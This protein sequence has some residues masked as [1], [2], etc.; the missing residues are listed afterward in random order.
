MDVDKLHSSEYTDGNTA[1]LT[2]LIHSEELSFI[3]EAHNALSAAVAARAGFKALW[4]SGLTI[5]SQ[6]GYRDA[7][8]ASW[9]EVV[10]VVG[11]MADS[12]GVPILVDGDTGFGN[13]NNARL[14]ARKLA[15]HGAAGV[16]LEDKTYP[17]MNSFVGDRHPLADIDEFCG[18][19]KAVKDAVGSDF[20]V[21]ARLEALIAGHGEAEALKRA[22]AYADAGADAVLIHSRKPH[23]GEILS[24]ARAWQRR[25]P[26]VI[27]PTKYYRTP[28][29]EY[30]AASISAVI[31]ANH[32]MRASVKAMHDVCRRI[33]ADES[34]A[35]IEA[36]VASLETL[37][38][39]MNYAELAAAESL[40]LP[41]SRETSP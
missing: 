6:L 40:Y 22:H 3:M 18:R 16:C 33:L 19:L 17:K 41:R 9:T 24:F 8:E 11:R 10:D 13:F 39:L 29:T 21:V 37:F 15:Q 23:A 32:S 35:G 1:S 34:I 5:C 38:E 26:V 25:L 2:A 7:S 30:R 31:W 28:V 12:S 36:E 14:F 4:A 20:V 27:V